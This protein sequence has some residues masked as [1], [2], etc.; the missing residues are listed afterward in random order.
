MS[1]I[2][3][4]AG[5]LT[6]KNAQQVI[7]GGRTGLTLF[8]MLIAFLLQA[9]GEVLGNSLDDFCIQHHLFSQEPLTEPALEAHTNIR[10]QLAFQSLNA[11]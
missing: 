3:N 9:K 7:R 6:I 8:D 4:T 11:N 5:L 2:N 1:A 10:A